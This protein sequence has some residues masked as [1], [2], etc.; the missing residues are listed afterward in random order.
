MKSG[1]H[2]KI[3][4]SPKQHYLKNFHL[5]VDLQETWPTERPTTQ[6]VITPGY[7][8]WE[9]PSVPSHQARWMRS[10]AKTNMKRHI[11]SQK[12]SW[13]KVSFQS[14]SILAEQDHGLSPESSLTYCS[15]SCMVPVMRL[16]SLLLPQDSYIS[17]TSVLLP[18]FKKVLTVVSLLGGKQNK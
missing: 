16:C 9:S 17:R 13:D 2:N 11:S 15:S 18:A 8:Q 4:N 5:H 7:R 10:M 1:I 12:Q 14:A 6:E 3:I